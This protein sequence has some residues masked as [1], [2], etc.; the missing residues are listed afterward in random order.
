MRE[1]N[2]KDELIWQCRIS[3]RYHG[4]R[5]GFLDSCHRV[6]FFT[7]F[8]SSALLA[9]GFIDNPT[10]VT[11]LTLSPVIAASLDLV[12]KFSIGAQAHNFLKQR[13]Y[14]LEMRLT[15]NKIS[16]KTLEEVEKEMVQLMADEPPGYRVL[17]YHC[18]NLVDIEKDK[19]PRLQISK[20][21][22]LLRNVLRFTGTS[23]QKIKKQ[24]KLTLLHRFWRGAYDT[25][26][27]VF[28]FAVFVV[29]FIILAYLGG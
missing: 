15:G 27:G 2:Q 28:V 22:M 18:N 21:K 29:L 8:T 26:W 12:L 20:W 7:I 6:V 1:K 14:H 16:D 24:K 3:S 13:F 10:I 23:P 5:G 4:Y 9:S 19:K 25:L 11:L 17:L